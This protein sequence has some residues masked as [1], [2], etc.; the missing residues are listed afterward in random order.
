[1]G[2]PRI[3]FVIFLGAENGFLSGQSRLLKLPGPRMPG[4]QMAEKLLYY[5]A[6]FKS[7]VDIVRHDIHPKER[8]NEPELN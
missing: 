1:M 2:T 3:R 4:K 5:L 6:R 8:M 7:F